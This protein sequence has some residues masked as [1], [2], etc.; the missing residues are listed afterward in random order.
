MIDL[1]V[2]RPEITQ[3]ELAAHFGYTEPWISQIIR[4]DAF[5][6]M[7]ALRKE[8]LVDPLILQKVEARFE[9]LVERSLDILQ[10]KL[11][12][13][14]APSADLAIKCAEL[15]ARSL[16]YGQA[17]GGPMVQNN[18]VV[19]MPDKAISAKEWLQQHSP[20]PNVIDVPATG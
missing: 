15:G 18:F 16:G 11:K 9:I 4:S 6:E 14:N 1:L 13:E 17:K 20:I 7:L 5:R 8:E 3:R 10:E 12:Q 2:A 19:A